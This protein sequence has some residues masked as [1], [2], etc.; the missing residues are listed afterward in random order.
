MSSDLPPD[1]NLVDL[2]ERRRKARDAMPPVEAG[3][4]GGA[5]DDGA[6]GALDAEYK[7]INRYAPELRGVAAGKWKNSP[8]EGEYGMPCPCPVTPLGRDDDGFWFL[9]AYGSVSCLKENAG[10]G[11]ID[12][13]F[14]PYAAYLAWAWPRM[15]GKGDARR[16]SGNFEA[17]EARQDLFAAASRAGAYD[18]MRRV[19]GRGAWRAEDGSGLICHMGDILLVPERTGRHVARA[20]G[21]HEGKAYPLR[22]SLPPP[23]SPGSPFPGE[24]DHD[25]PG[26]VLFED[27][28]SWLWARG[29][30]DAML[31]LGWTALAPFGGALRWRPYVFATGDQGAGKSTLITYTQ[32]VLGGEEALFRSEDTTEAGVAQSLGHDAIPVLLDEL[33]PQADNT[34]AEQ[35]VRMARR[36]SS[37]AV[38]T[39]GGADGVSSQTIVRSCIM[40]AAINMPTLEDQ[41]T[42]RMAIL[43]MSP[44]APGDIKKRKPLNLNRAAALG[45]ALHRQVLD[46]FAGD[47]EASHQSFDAL[48][49][50]VREGLREH[51]GHDD[52]GADTF[53]FLLAGYWAATSRDMPGPAD[54]AALVK[55]FERASLAEYENI[56][57]GWRKC[58]NYLMDVQPKQL[59]R[60]ANATVREILTAW[61]RGEDPE[62]GNIYTTEAAGGADHKWAAKQLKKVGLRLYHAPGDPTDF[63][64]GWL[65]VPNIMPALSTLFE[66]SSWRSASKGSAGGWGNALNGAPRDVVRAHRTGE[67]RGKLVRLSALRISAAFEEAGGGSP[68]HEEG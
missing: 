51:G 44:F 59:E 34:R 56:Q 24:E 9:N 20:V 11:N 13:L 43:A 32:A 48:V 58:L 45:R 68:G 52:R 30:L 25:T 4:G 1:T 21:V 42:A 47:R 6:L 5:G 14:A 41:D 28:R 17:E 65:F 29:D 8:M 33:E 39:R 18:P 53:G 10:K 16:A 2:T 62:P 35:M 23:A 38:R 67:H 64:H 57:P 22:P 36:A 54:I 55:G 15:T 61:A 31:M 12:A 60:Q 26:G 37:G 46:W 27:Y 49:E 3:P 66:G 50:T 40:F 63:E 7:A 19:R